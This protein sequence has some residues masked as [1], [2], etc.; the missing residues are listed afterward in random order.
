MSKRW[1]IIIVVCVVIILGGLVAFNATRDL[2][3]RKD[4]RVQKVERKDLVSVVTASGEIKPKRYV[5]VSS[6]VP[7]RITQMLV[8]EGDVVRTGQPLC[9]IDATPFEA[10][11]RQATAA[12]QAARAD[13]QRAQ[14][15]LEAS[16]LAFERVKKMQADELVS[17]QE[18]DQARAD[19]QMKQANVEGLKRRITQ[20]EAA[21]EYDTNN[22]S[23]TTVLATMD[24]VVTALLK[25]EGETVIGAQSFQPTVIMTIADLSV[26]EAEVLV[27]ETDIRSLALGQEAKVRVDALPDAEIVG[28]VTE[29]G[30]SAQVRGAAAGTTT[31]AITEAN[32]AKDFRVTITLDKPPASLRPGLNATADITTARKHNVLAVPIQAVVVREVDK[33]GNVVEPRTMD[34]R[35]GEASEVVEARERGE[36]TEG[37]FVVEKGQANFRRVKTGIMGETDIEILSGLKDGEEIVSGSYRTLRTLADKAHVKVE[38]SKKGKTQ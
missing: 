16:R 20:Q 6:D 2:R 7:G 1:K 21:L 23:K 36:E 35:N 25:E 8:K 5:N 29:I 32:Q 12:L 30:A 11:N 38:K 22:L 24:G 33:Q 28:H 3:N 34:Q 9:R 17:Q 37:V 19:F 15:D 4:V 13:L 14:A 18:F 27:D 10:S 26:M 31:S